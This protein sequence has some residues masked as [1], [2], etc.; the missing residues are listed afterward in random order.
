MGQCFCKENVEG[1]S[2]SQCIQGYFGLDDKNE[3][4]CLPCEC[5][6]LADSCSLIEDLRRRVFSIEASDDNAFKIVDELMRP[7]SDSMLDVYSNGTI[8]IDINLLSS[9]SENFGVFIGLPPSWVDA[10]KSAF[11]YAR[12]AFTIQIP[13]SIIQ[14]PF[15]ARDLLMNVGRLSLHRSFPNNVTVGIDPVRISVDLIGQGWY[16]KETELDISDLQRLLSE[17]AFIAIRVGFSFS[18][19]IIVRDV[20]LEF[21]Q[22][23]NDASLPLVQDE[24]LCHCPDAYDGKSL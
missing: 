7:L 24:E 12:L 20:E 15:E 5:K 11:S 17:V 8:W 6:D 9:T 19:S 21:Y 22:L 4:G 13:E 18:H 16:D 1:D 2:C 10:L 14:I 23:S 3:E